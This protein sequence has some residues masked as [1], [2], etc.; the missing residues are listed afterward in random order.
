MAKKPLP[1]VS[2]L[3]QLLRCDAENGKLF[4]KP[5]TDSDLPAHAGRTS[6]WRSAAWN[7]KLADKEAFTST[8]ANGYRRGIILGYQALAHRVIW[9]MHYGEWPVGFIDHVNGIP[10]DNRISNLR[11]A[12]RSENGR[13]RMGALATSRFKGVSATGGAGL[14]WV[15]K[16]TLNKKIRHLGRFACE[17]AAAIAYDRAALELHGEFALTNAMIEARKCL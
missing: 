17:A 10:D 2:V 4:W 16:I 11:L 1:P 6:K 7:G 13:N 15:A 12:T 8:N 5:R 3:C 9:A 14:P